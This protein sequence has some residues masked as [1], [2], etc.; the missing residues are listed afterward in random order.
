M[1]E[2]LVDIIGKL[3]FWN[4]AISPSIRFSSQY[5]AKCQIF[6]CHAEFRIFLY[7]AECR[8]AQW[9]YDELLCWVPWRHR[10]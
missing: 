1:T 4:L 9:L 3:T 8:Y 2:K 10:E 6:Y 5:Y 7:D